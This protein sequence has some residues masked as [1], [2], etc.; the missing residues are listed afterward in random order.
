MIIPIHQYTSSD[1]TY[2][3][4]RLI[5]I[6][7]PVIKQAM[8]PI[9]KLQKIRGCKQPVRDDKGVV[10]GTSLEF[11]GSSYMIFL[12]FFSGL[13]DGIAFFWV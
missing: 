1:S 7:S 11:S 13:F 2:T 8:Y 6:L 5:A 12:H 4:I 9:Q 3:V 10:G